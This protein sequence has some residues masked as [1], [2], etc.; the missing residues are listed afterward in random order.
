MAGSTY[1]TAHDLAVLAEAMTQ[2]YP[3]LYRRFFGHRGLNWGGFAQE[4]HDPVTGRV[5]GAD[6]IKTGYTNEAGFTFLGSAERD[7]R[8]LAMV[9]AGAPSEGM[10]DD[11]AARAARMGLCRIFP[12]DLAW[13]AG[14]WWAA[15]VSRTE[16]MRRS[17]CA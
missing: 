6:G 7:G 12:P 9:L 10:R 14:R 2:R 17:D 5:A 4:N 13:R 3:G 8:R 15:Q 16:L 11:T 1:T